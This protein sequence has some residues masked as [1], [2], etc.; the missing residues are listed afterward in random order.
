MTLFVDLSHPEV[1]AFHASWGYEKVDESKP[2][3]DSPTFAVMPRRLKPS[4]R[5]DGPA[6]GG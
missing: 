2:Y 6:S 3:D 5:G 1:V 4:G